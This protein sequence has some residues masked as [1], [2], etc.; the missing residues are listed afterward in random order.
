MKGRWLFVK[1]LGIVKDLFG[2]LFFFMFLKLLVFI[3]L[4]NFG[5]I[6]GMVEIKYSN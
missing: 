5:M 2:E 6:G 4:D 1:V 3:L